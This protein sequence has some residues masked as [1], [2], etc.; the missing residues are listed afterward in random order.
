MLNQQAGRG[1]EG[2]CSPVST[3]TV[4]GFLFICKGMALPKSGHALLNPARDLFKIRR[5]LSLESICL[6]RPQLAALRLS[7]GFSRADDC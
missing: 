1:I 2:K 6:Y 3:S 7:G 4:L 5:R